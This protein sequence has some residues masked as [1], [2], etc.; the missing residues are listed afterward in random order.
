M[1]ARPQGFLPPIHQGAAPRTQPRREARLAGETQLRK[2]PL[3]DWK[4]AEHIFRG[5]IAA[6][7]SVYA[8]RIAHRSRHA[9]SFRSP[10]LIQLFM[11][12]S[13]TLDLWASSS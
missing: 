12:P 1:A 7:A 13:G 2:T 9:L 4:H 3:L 8:V 10:R 6:I 11:V 5:E